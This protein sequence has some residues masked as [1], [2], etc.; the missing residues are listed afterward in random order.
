MRKKI[1]DIILAT[2]AIF[3][4]LSSV[5]V[6]ENVVWGK[7]IFAV[8]TA[9]YIVS[10]MQMKYTGDDF[11][12]KRL[13]RYIYISSVLLLAASYLQ[14]KGNNVWVILLFIT[15]INELYCTFRTSWYEK[16]T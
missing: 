16:N 1:Y 10:R 14:F 5:L 2:G 9:F 8:G 15:A 3:I 4:L 7:Y 12:I 13:N 11:R 6:M